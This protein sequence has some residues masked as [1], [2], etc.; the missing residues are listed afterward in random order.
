MWGC[1]FIVVTPVTGETILYSKLED[2]SFQV[3]ESCNHVCYLSWLVSTEPTSSICRG[4]TEESLVCFR[5]GMDLQISW[6]LLH[7]HA[8]QLLV[9]LLLKVPSNDPSTWR[10]APKAISLCLIAFS[11]HFD[12]V[13]DVQSL[14]ISLLGRQ[15]GFNAESCFSICHPS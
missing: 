4:F 14:W 7:T 11:S 5:P 15:T 1:F 10:K 12:I 9:L 8:I 6:C 3:T 2:M 13:N